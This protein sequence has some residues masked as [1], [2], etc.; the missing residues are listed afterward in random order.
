MPQ[1]PGNDLILGS[2]PAGHA[3]LGLSRAMRDKHLYVCG[4]TGTGKSKLL[5]SLIRQDIVSW[6]KSRCGLLLIDPHGS[7]YDSLLDWLAFNRLER[8]IV[9]I[10]LR[11][12]DWIVSYNLL[13]QRQDADPAVFTRNFVDAMAYAWGALGTDQ[14][15]RLTRW[16]ANVVR[17]LYERQR[18]IVDAQYLID[19]VQGGIRRLLTNDLS[20]PATRQDW[21][22]ANT[23]KPSQ[24]E[25][26]LGSTISRLRPFLQ[27]Q[28]ISSMFGIS[29]AS[30][31]LR[32]ALDDGQ[33]VL[34]CVATEKGKIAHNDSEVF[35]TLLL[36]DLWLAAQERGIPRGVGRVGGR[37]DLPEGGKTAA[38]PHRVELL[39]RTLKEGDKLLRISG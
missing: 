23:L 28:R 12:D 27:T 9:P 30:F 37:K 24:F 3:T 5:E 22:F 2:I 29:K 16:A 8:P 39:D 26:Q 21:K 13:R 35:A 32:Q 15:P 38:R 33:I 4:T 34:A 11:Q 7:L 17:A 6:R 20:D 19:Q 10:D 1:G 31:D 14:T 25:E 36:T 18:T